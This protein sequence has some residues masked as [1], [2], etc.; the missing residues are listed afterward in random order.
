MWRFATYQH[1]STDGAVGVYG[2]GDRLLDSDLDRDAGLSPI[3]SSKIARASIAQTDP[4]PGDQRLIDTEIPSAL[5]SVERSML[6]F[7][8][9]KKSAANSPDMSWRTSA[10]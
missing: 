1:E 6:W 8:N 4:K 2:A 3:L 10:D 7:L 9:M 5:S